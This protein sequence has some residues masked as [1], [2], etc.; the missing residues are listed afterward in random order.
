MTKY[1]GFW[2]RFAAAFIDGIILGIFQRIFEAIVNSPPIIMIVAVV[3]AWLYGA[4]MESSPKQATLGKQAVG[5]IVTD[6]DGK[7]ISFLRA[8]GRYFAK[9]LSMIIL[10]IGYIMAG[11]T[12][13]KQALHDMVAG[14]LVI[15]K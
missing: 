13:K 2:K 9:Y 14:T 6:L 4:L 12:E 7:Q 10:F 15:N 1:A 11:F 8:T 5:I 3:V